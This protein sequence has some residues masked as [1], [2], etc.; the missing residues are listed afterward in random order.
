M[1]GASFVPAD[2]PGHALAPGS[3]AA[4][5][6]TFDISAPTWA[7]GFPLPTSLGGASVTFN[8]KPAPLFYVSS[9]QINA[10]VPGDTAAG[11]E[12]SA[13]GSAS[14]VVTVAGHSSAPVGADVLP[15]NPMLFTQGGSGCGAG[16]ILNVASDGRVSVNS[17]SDSAS[18]GDFIEVYGTGLGGTAPPAEDGEPAPSNPLSK[19]AVY[20]ASALFDAATVPMNAIP[21]AVALA[22]VAFAGR[23]P[24]FAGVDQYNVQ[25]PPGVREGCSV[26]VRIV[27]NYV[28]AESQPVLVSIHTGGGPCADPPVWGYG[29]I[30]IKK[31]VILNDPKTPETD[32]FSARFPASPGLV[33]PTPLPANGQVVVE[34]VPRSPR[35][36]I[37]GHKTLSAG[38]IV[39][40]NPQGVP[41]QV[42]PT[43]ASDG[44]VSY[45]ATLPAGFVQPGTYRLA[46]AGAGVGSFQASLTA[47]ADISVTSQYPAGST[48][49]AATG[50]VLYPVNWTGGEAGEAATLRVDSDQFVS[51]SVWL[52][53]VPAAAGTVG[54]PVSYLGGV[55]G[56]SQGVQYP[57]VPTSLP[58]TF[59]IRVDV[60][61]DPSKIPTF[62]APG[63]TLGG[64]AFVVYEYRFTGLNN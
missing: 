2:A 36:P 40:T 27:S 11:T 52:V 64:R 7:S 62:T 44:S 51:D 37:P 10:E 59:E 9:T 49:G 43:I 4:I 33:L 23:A 26:P 19:P 53:R 30:V 12:Y 42:Q 39:V 45:S 48:V 13:Y 56:Q 55:P 41:V 16:A 34:A 54:I 17:A 46:A 5:F 31:S 63:L 1:N 32:T 38:P 18:P 57:Q 50:N 15:V 8:G 6:G 28:E 61:P 3:I 25:I 14:V 29:E 58:G 21:Y 24:G 20:G 60:G 22:P 35:C 47:G